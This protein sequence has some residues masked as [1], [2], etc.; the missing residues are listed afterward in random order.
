MHRM[1]PITWCH[2]FKNDGNWKDKHA[3][4]GQKD[5]ESACQWFQIEQLEQG[6]RMEHFQQLTCCHIF[7]KISMQIKKRFWTYSRRSMPVIS[8][9]AWYN[10]VKET[11]DET[12]VFEVVLRRFMQKCCCYRKLHARSETEEKKRKKLEPV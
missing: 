5:C 2:C 6:L 1:S 12:L 8:D 3:N 10:K 4:L 7:K 9:W 11:K